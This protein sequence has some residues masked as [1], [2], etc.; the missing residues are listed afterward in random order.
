MS[1][2]DQYIIIGGAIGCSG[3]HR[4]NHLT[5]GPHGKHNASFCTVLAP[6]ISAGECVS[7]VPEL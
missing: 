4:K 1:L 2:N 3:V 6:M 7:A 5:N